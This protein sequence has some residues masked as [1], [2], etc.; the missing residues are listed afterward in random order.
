VQLV[1]V[2]I[3]RYGLLENWKLGTLAPGLNLIVGGNEAG[4]TTLLS[5]I[6][7]ILF[8]FPTGRQSVKNDYRLN[9]EDRLGGRLLLKSRD[10]PEGLTI[11]RHTGK[12]LGP[13]G[14][15]LPDG[16]RLAEE[17]LGRLLGNLD[18][19]LY[20]NVF[21]FGLRELANLETLNSE[22][23]QARIYSAG[24]GTGT[25]TVP[26]ALKRL[27][28]E[29]EDIFKPS[30]RKPQIN[31]V[32]SQIQSLEKELSQLGALADRYTELVSRRSEMESELENLTAQ[33][34]KNAE[35][36]GQKQR[37][38]RGREAWNKYCEVQTHL[39]ELEA[40][41]EDFPV[42]AEE[43]LKELNESIQETH[44]ELE[45]LE[46]KLGQEK[47]GFVRKEELEK[48]LALREQITPIERGLGQYNKAL[49][50]LPQ[51]KSDLDSI[52][53]SLKKKIEE[54]NRG[55]TVK[56]LLEFDNSIATRDRYRATKQAL[57]KSKLELIQAE[58]S[59][60]HAEEEFTRADQA[61]IQAESIF[62]TKYAGRIFFLKKLFFLAPMTALALGIWMLF[63]G[64]TTTGI[65]LEVLAVGLFIGWLWVGK[66]LSRISEIGWLKH[67][68]GIW[69][70]ERKDLEKLSKEKEDRGQKLESE[71]RKKEQLSYA[72]KSS[73][74]DFSRFLGGL[75]LEETL[76]PDALGDVIGQVSLAREELGKAEQLEKRIVEIEGFVEEYHRKVCDLFGEMEQ[77]EPER[78]ET[79]GA[80]GKLL[81]DLER[82]RQ[83]QT[84]KKMH[85]QKLE[86]L[87]DQLGSQQEKLERFLRD[88]E[89]LTAVSA[90]QEDETS[91]TSEERFQ[92]HARVAA[93]RELWMGGRKEA[94]SQ[95]AVHA[96]SPEALD[97][98]LAELRKTSF[99]RLGEEVESLEEERSAAAQEKDRI[100]RQLGENWK[101]M[102]QVSTETA[103][104][105]FR[106]ERAVAVERLAELAE[107]WAVLTLAAKVVRLA[108]ER[109]EK[110]RQ[111][112]VL[113]HGQKYFKQM[114]AGRYERIFNPVG[115][116]R[117]EVLTTRGRRLPPEKL[118]RGTA[119]QLYLALRL[120]LI[121][122]RKTHS[123]P[124]P[125]MMD[126][127]LVNFDSPR[128]E[129]ACQAIA[130]IAKS[131]QVIYLTC[132][133][134]IVELFQKQLPK[135]N[136]LRLD[137]L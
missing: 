98:Y 8:G 62:K 74:E 66:A 120:G 42:H 111:P 116:Q 61:C 43:R 2:E 13:L 54:I 122:E 63:T 19:T 108:M 88:K 46:R 106:L 28:K 126:D 57:E 109:Y 96:G 65:I 38:L 137:I 115:E 125:I 40:L 107:R 91:E 31:A 94:L 15:Y 68:P 33:D 24:T 113:R 132:H 105:K 48:I 11:E 27:D 25:V 14:L 20:L 60:H 37:L 85:E 35:L 95:L 4:K 7:N 92:K 114:T 102:T 135:A 75:G 16:G 90:L 6:R 1:G 84:G 47:A 41:P 112:E 5:F 86:Y 21:A 79:A 83:Y 22:E 117:F 81:Q 97:K 121:E 32:L 104:G 64:A 78:K 134:H 58:Q 10:Y 131:H 82:A 51:R 23:L 45:E 99:D 50:D 93:E 80:M 12:G 70:E 34:R 59:M 119:E 123:E 77:P 39:S 100:N 29:R 101:E 89:K 56:E 18:R 26:E 30:G 17:V 133:P 129:A 9:P 127:I 110:E 53:E 44:S 73:Q 136:M 124:V 103:A 3:E 36:L 49:D 87:N 72:L 130:R 76:S 67:L 128:A 52:H 118:S 55:W 71:K 69:P